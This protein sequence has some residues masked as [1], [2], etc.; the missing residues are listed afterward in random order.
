MSCNV[1]KEYVSFISKNYVEYIKLVVGK[2]YDKE[3]V[4]KY[5][6]TYLNIRYYHTELEIKTNLESTI[7]YYLNKVYEEN[8]SDISKFI[9]ELFKV[10]YYIDDVREFK[11]KDDFK[12]YVDELY[13]IKIE[14]LKLDNKEFKNLFMTLVKDNEKRKRKYLNSF[15]TKDFYLCMDKVTSKNIY[16]VRLNYNIEISDIFSTKAVNKVYNESLVAE[17]KLYI[18]YYLVNKYLLEDII[19]CNFKREYLVEFNVNLFNKKDKL[20]RLLNIMDNDIAK[21]NIIIK[22]SYK[23]FLKNKDIVYNYI[24]L[25]YKFGIIIDDTY[26]NQPMNVSGLDIFKYVLITSKKYEIPLLLDKPNI[27][28]IK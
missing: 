9:F 18:E 23:D 5:L 2:Y 26:I 6:E 19:S 8:N 20:K 1:I 14:K 22:I 24:K 16:N 12:K 13:S 25:G 4:S 10:F 17:N 11:S 28:I 7:N 27:L 3:L 15:D 21:E